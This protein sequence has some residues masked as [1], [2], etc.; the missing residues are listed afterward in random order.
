MT[1]LLDIKNLDLLKKELEEN[2]KLIGKLIVT[3]S[4][5][6]IIIRI[7]TKNAINKVEEIIDADD[8]IYQCLYCGGYYNDMSID[9]H[10]KCIPSEW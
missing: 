10:G 7:T 8:D 3:V 6:E 9:L 2:S 4:E 5:V 1:W